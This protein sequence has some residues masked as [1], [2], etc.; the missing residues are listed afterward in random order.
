MGLYCWLLRAFTVHIMNLH[1]G[2]D[3]YRTLLGRHLMK[4]MFCKT[5]LAEAWQDQLQGPFWNEQMWIVDSA[6]SQD[7]WVQ[8]SS[9]DKLCDG[10]RH[11][12]LPL[13]ASGFF[14][15]TSEGCGK[16]YAQHLTH[17]LNEINAG[18][19]PIWCLMSCFPPRSPSIALLN[20][21]W[22]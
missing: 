5:Q 1:W 6:R 18:F 8:N 9:I 3:L 2:D 14:K 15:C 11:I 17:A 12:I 10:C 13:W 19:L 16:G 7:T 20:F 4:L 21:L 22:K